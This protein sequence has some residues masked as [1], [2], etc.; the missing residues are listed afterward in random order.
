MKPLTQES[1]E[2]AL[3]SSVTRKPG[4][5][6]MISGPMSA[7]AML[8]AASLATVDGSGST[9]HEEVAGVFRSGASSAGASIRPLTTKSSTIQPRVALPS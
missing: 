6:L 1:R 7:T 5:G 9:G 4:A 2:E 8:Q 3:P